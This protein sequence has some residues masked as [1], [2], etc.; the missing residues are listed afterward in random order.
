MINLTLTDTCPAWCTKKDDGGPHQ[1]NSATVVRDGTFLELLRDW[2][3]DVTL[4]T[5]LESMDGGGAFTLRANTLAQL[6]AE[7]ARLMAA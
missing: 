3:S 5:V 2:G 4:A 1:H 6:G 7:A